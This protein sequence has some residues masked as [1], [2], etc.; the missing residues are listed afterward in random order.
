MVTY[1]R[2]HGAGRTLLV[3]LNLA[4]LVGGAL[5]IGGLTALGISRS[6]FEQISD[7]SGYP[8]GTLFGSE[9]AGFL[10]SPTVGWIAL[11]AL[12]CLVAKELIV[13][14]LTLR[15]G[16]NAVSLALAGGTLAYIVYALYVVPIGNA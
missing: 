14:R 7:S 4:L 11:L 13:S 15:L 3:L 10:L 6:T 16:I 2:R 8:S 1:I 12:A 5:A 9:V